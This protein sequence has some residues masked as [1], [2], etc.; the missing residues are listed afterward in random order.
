M[1]ELL[2][3]CDDNPLPSNSLT[4]SNGTRNSYFQAKHDLVEHQVRESIKVKQTQKLKDTRA[5]YW[6]SGDR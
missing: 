2:A 6:V 3:T 4:A 5:D 1:A